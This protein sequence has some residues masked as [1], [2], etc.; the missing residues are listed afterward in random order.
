M[1]SER[2]HPCAKGSVGPCFPRGVEWCF[3]PANID[4]LEVVI[5]VYN[6]YVSVESVGLNNLMDAE[7]APSDGDPTRSEM[8]EGLVTM[9]ERY[10]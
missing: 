2:P 9:M 5:Q 1:Q 10:P 6:F 8:C 7:I 4:T 3:N